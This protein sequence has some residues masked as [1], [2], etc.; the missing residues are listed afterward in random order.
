MSQLQ[1]QLRKKT[2]ELDSKTVTHKEFITDK[3]RSTAE[4]RDTKRIL[5]E[6][7]ESERQL[8]YELNDTKKH[9]DEALKQSKRNDQILHDRTRDFKE[10]QQSFDRKTDLYNFEVT[11]LKQQL[12]NTTLHNTSLEDTNLSLQTEFLL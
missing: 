3:N 8:E 5:N 11:Q 1:D 10:A 7:K 6:N 2:E 4:L 9:L 12:L